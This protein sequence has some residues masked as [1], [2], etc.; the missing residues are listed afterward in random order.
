MTPASGEPMQKSKIPVL[1]LNVG[2]PKSAAVSDVRRYLAEFLMDPYVIPIPTPLRFALVRGWA[3]PVRSH[4]SAELYR[5]I[6]TSEGSPLLVHSLRFAALLQE[7]LGHDYHVELGMRYGEPS[8]E[9]ALLRLRSDE[10]MVLVPLFPQYAAAVTESCIQK[11]LSFLP[12]GAHPIAV[13]Y[14]YND[15]GYRSAFLSRLVAEISQ[16]Q[17]DH[18]LFSFHG[19]PTSEVTKRDPSHQHCLRRNDCCDFDLPTNQLCYRAQCI[20]TAKGFAA[21]LNLSPQGY[22]VAF[23]SRL[24]GQK[25]LG[26]QSE[27]VY[28]SLPS[29]GVKKLLVACPGFVADCLETLEEVSIRGAALFQKAGG[30]ALQLVPALNSHPTWVTAAADLIRRTSAH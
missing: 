7:E 23:Q 9:S 20:R 6:W 26:P 8:I 11:V 19:L 1:L 16:F 4:Y 2:T 22:S 25:W 5:R 24:G 30:E 14:F 28:Q 29:A 12:E 3:A 13:P 27:D 17:P 10:R 15:A 21:A 18:V